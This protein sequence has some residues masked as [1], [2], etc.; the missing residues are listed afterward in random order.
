MLKLLANEVWAFDAEWVPD[1]HT[2][3]RVYGCDPHLS[4]DEVLQEMWRAG[5]ATPSDPTPYL[6]TVLCR[7]VSVSALIRKQDAEGNV[8]VKLHS[9]PIGDAGPLAERELLTRFLGALGKARPQ[10]VGYNSVSADIPIL[11]QRALVNG[12]TSPEFCK[13]PNKPWEGIDY[14]ARG[15]DHNVDLKEEL[16]GWGKGTPSLHEIATACGIPGKMDTTGEDVVNLWKQ[17]NIARIVQYNECDALTTYLLWLRLAHFAGLIDADGYAREQR[18]LE[19]Y[20]GALVS[21]G[22]KPHLVQYLEKWVALR[23]TP[24]S[25]VASAA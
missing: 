12:V 13:R 6:K 20:V 9:I 11:I 24:G 3:R 14:F 5:G 1:P 4:D 16:S 25:K 17:G 15:S 7:V 19:E 22:A 10:V 8:S 23:S 2:G 18:G 21:T